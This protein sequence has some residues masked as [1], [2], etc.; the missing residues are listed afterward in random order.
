MTSHENEEELVD[1]LI[2]SG[3]LEP[4]GIDENGD[5]L[6]SFTEKLAQIDPKLYE[7]LM[8]AFYED[9]KFL[10]VHGFL[11]MDITSSNPKVRLTERAFDINAVSKL[12]PELS[13]SL[14][15]IVYA[16][17]KK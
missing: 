8:D 2:L 6:F 17:R 1:K 10:W 12:P 13:R 9:V 11:D 7:G 5:M 14:G 3:A 15:Y 4:A 16:L